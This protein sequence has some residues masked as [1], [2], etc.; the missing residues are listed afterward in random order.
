MHMC[1]YSS[2][3]L[4]STSGWVAY[5]AS[6]PRCLLNPSSASIWR[7]CI[8]HLT[9]N[10]PQLMERLRT[11]CKRQLPLLRTTAASKLAGA[12]VVTLYEDFLGPDFAGWAQQECICIGVHSPP[13]ASKK[14][15][16]I[17]RYIYIYIY[18]MIYSNTDYIDICFFFS[19]S[20]LLRTVVS[21]LSRHPFPRPL[22]RLSRRPWICGCV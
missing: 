17:Y 12:M 3:W 22:H 11:L 9:F 19:C 20:P 13:C 1:I 10:L 8:I 6:I 21:L 4:S 5:L 15:I 16:C 7:T 14:R 18:I 2:G